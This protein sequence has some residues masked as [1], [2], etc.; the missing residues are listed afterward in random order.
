ML[1]T[2]LWRLLGTLALATTVLGCA[3]V[4]PV[5]YNELASAPSLTPNQGDDAATIAYRYAPPV[6]WRAYD[7][8]II[9]PVAIY[10]APDNQF[11]DLPESD[12]ASLAAF[13]QEQFTQKL[14]PR[15]QITT[16]AGPKTLRLKLTLTG[17]VKTTPVLGTLSRFDLMGGLYN[18]VQSIRGGEGTFTGAVIYA[19]EFYDAGTSQLLA[20]SI[21][22]QYPNAL[23]IGAS[24][25]ALGAART[26][27]E[28]GAEKMAEQLQ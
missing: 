25:G 7:K 26:G 6:N 4:K 11:G 22:K 23:N 10:R 5:P 18:G 12:K 27:I 13:M 17:V 16:V 3:S 8:L 9:D 15:F 28:K 14:A 21:I 2:S 19:A 20:A 24:F 1:K